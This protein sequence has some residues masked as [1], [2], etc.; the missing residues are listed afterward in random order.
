VFFNGDNFAVG[1]IPIGPPDQA[2]DDA[3]PFFALLPSGFVEGVHVGPRTAIDP[4]T[5]QSAVIPGTYSLVQGDPRLPMDPLAKITA[6]QGTYKNFTKTL[7]SLGNNPQGFEIIAF[8]SRLD[9]GIDDIV[10]F[11]ISGL[12]ITNVY[13]GQ[14]DMNAGTLSAFPVAQIVDPENTANE[15]TGTISALDSGDVRL[16]HA[17]HYDLNGTNLPATFSTS[18][19]FIVYRR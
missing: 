1:Q 7:N 10:M 3:L 17:G 15:I 11:N 19:R 8:P 9:D 12:V 4:G 14:I 13:F 5:G 2:T 16:V 18:G 6:I